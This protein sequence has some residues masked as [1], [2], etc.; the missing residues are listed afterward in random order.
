MSNIS[1]SKKSYSKKEDVLLLLQ[2]SGA[3]GIK[4]QQLIRKCGK[5]SPARIY[6]L[7]DDGYKI[8][9]EPSRGPKC[10]YVL[11]GKYRVAKKAPTTKRPKGVK[12]GRKSA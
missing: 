3:K 5:R 2:K 11:V 6:D 12:R 7:R 10:T 8:T 4:V 9:T 1:V